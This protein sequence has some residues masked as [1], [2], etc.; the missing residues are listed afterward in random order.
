MSGTPIMYKTE[1]FKSKVYLY[2]EEINA[3]LK[4]EGGI[5]VT[6]PG[7]AFSAQMWDG[8]ANDGG[9]T[10]TP[11][12]GCRGRSHKHMQHRG[13]RK[14]CKM[15]GEGHMNARH[16]EVVFLCMCIQDLYV[17]CVRH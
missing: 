13:A 1:T 17:P 3:F 15:E 9:V 2:S 8:M 4:V 12:D 16:V 14:T 11:A 7:K 6:Q 10:Q 5:L